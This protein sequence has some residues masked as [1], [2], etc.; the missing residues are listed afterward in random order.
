MRTVVLA[1]AS[2]LLALPALAADAPARTG[3]EPV[4]PY[5]ETDANAGATPITDPRVFQ[6]F[7]GLAGVERIITEAQRLYNT[8]PRISDIFKAA[9]QA[10]LHRTLVEQV[11]YILGGPCHYSG[12]DMAT[13]HKDMGLQVSDMNALV[14][15]LQKAMDKERVPFADQNRLLAKLAPI[16]RVVVAR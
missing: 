9:D 13:A 11:C 2:G 12:R 8:D 4:A 10:R 3:E 5:V 7:H 1:L 16:K 14:E 15:D 6:A